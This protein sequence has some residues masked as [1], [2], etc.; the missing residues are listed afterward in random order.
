MFSKYVTKIVFYESINIVLICYKQNY[1]PIKKTKFCT[2][3]QTSDEVLN[4]VEHET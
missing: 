1:R 4:D 2:K 3:T